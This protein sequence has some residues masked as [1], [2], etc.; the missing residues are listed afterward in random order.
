MTK[1]TLLKSFLLFFFLWS[2]TISYATED[3]YLKIISPNTSAECAKY[4]LV[5]RA[6]AED[7]IKKIVVGT[8]EYMVPSSFNNQTVYHD[9]NN[10]RNLKDSVFKI[11]ITTPGEG[12]YV[13]LLMVSQLGINLPILKLILNNNKITPAH[14]LKRA[15][16][17]RIE[18]IS[19]DCEL[20]QPGKIFRFFYLNDCDDLMP[21]EDTLVI[22]EPGIITGNIFGKTPELDFKDGLEHG[23][24]AMLYAIDKG[25]RDSGIR[26]KYDST[27]TAYDTIVHIAEKNI[28]YFERPSIKGV[29][30]FGFS[31]TPI[32][33]V[34]TLSNKFCSKSY[35]PTID[36]IVEFDH[37]DLFETKIL[38]DTSFQIT[39]NAT[40]SG[41]AGF[42]IK[43]RNPSPFNQ[44]VESTSFG[45]FAYNSD[46][47]IKGKI[48][49]PNGL[50]LKY[51]QLLGISDSIV[52]N[53]EGEFVIPKNKNW[54]GDIYIEIPGK[55][56][57]P[58]KY[59]IKSLSKDTIL[60]FEVRD[61][62][63]NKLTVKVYEGSK[64]DNPMENVEITYE[65]TVKTNSEGLYEDSLYMGWTGSIEAKYPSYEFSKKFLNNV[66][67]DQ[68]VIF[69]GMY[70]GLYKVSGHVFNKESV[71]IKGFKIIKAPN[72][73]YGPDRDTVYTDENGYYEYQLPP[74]WVGSIT[75]DYKEGNANRYMDSIS[76]LNKHITNLDFYVDR[77]VHFND[78]YLEHYFINNNTI[79]TNKNNKIELSEALAF[80]G[81]LDLRYLFEEDDL[82]GIE[83]FRNTTG[84]RLDYSSKKTF[85]FS[86]FP[87]LQ[88]VY[89][90]DTELTEMDL[91]ENNKIE[92]VSSTSN[93]SL[94]TICLNDITKVKDN[95]YFY[96]DPHTQWS[97]KCNVVTSE[98]EFSFSSDFTV[99]PNPA[100]N[101]EINIEWPGNQS[102]ATIRIVSI[103]GEETLN[104][105]I[106]NGSKLHFNQKGMFF[107]HLNTGNQTLVKKV[108]F[109]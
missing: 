81:N 74:E 25:Y 27:K 35:Q 37:K 43:Y 32:T 46:H 48:T 80:N 50:P 49:E 12:T 105:E 40:E 11:P 69:H 38:D 73:V 33:K 72:Y 17:F 14:D 30:T 31:R 108:Q 19:M 60:N 90:Y 18:N 77:Y 58:N 42:D 109:R 3:R 10:T 26:F 96:K 54:S 23:D 84:I 71:P 63:Y 103:T 86:L 45:L 20:L 85:D 83:A 57:V 2:L 5:F 91:S 29:S 15:N 16:T 6:H 1:R 53:S 62:G 39:Y 36:S 44:E 100:N 89:A 61:P 9:E 22:Q 67:V 41:Y 8:K 106:S 21:F 76:L 52:S 87:N 98:N 47:Y 4:E 102:K 56:I 78:P 95:A 97:D 107:I 55:T 24:V 75:I 28:N 88:T 7:G 94:N 92:R 104:K 13:N 34:Y 99:Y 93:D 70:Q 65:K 66:T 51:I 59:E 101:G 68:E 82:T 64:T 79:N